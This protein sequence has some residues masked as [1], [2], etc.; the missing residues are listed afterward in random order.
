MR[1]LIFGASGNT[2]NELVKQALAKHYHVT[3]FVRNPSAFSFSHTML[4][5]VQG[6][7]V[8][9]HAVAGA[10]KEQDA[11]LCA[12][13]AAT[14]FKRD[15]GLV[16]G[17]ENIMKA[18]Q[19]QGVS[20]FIYLSF[21]GVKESRQHL[22]FFVN[23]VVAPL[24]SNVIRDHEAKETII[25]RSPLNW[26]IVRPPKLTTGARTGGFRFGEKIKPESLI[27][28]ISRA[29]LAAFILSQLEDEAF[30]RKA[31]CVMY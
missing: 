8:D 24:L 4:H 20:R 25:K 21:I 18:M 17:I 23:Y 19:N 6:D 16:A 22:G 5:V 2:G 1:I 29:D 14:P 10:I 7:V 27:L 30:I 13:G 3:A 15:H 9:Y 12:L 31:V 28:S 11:V 26:T